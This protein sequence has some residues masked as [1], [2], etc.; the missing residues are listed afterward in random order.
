MGRLL[1]KVCALMC[2][3]LAL[4]CFIVVEFKLPIDVISIL[5]TNCNLRFIEVKYILQ[6]VSIVSLLLF[7]LFSIAIFPEPLEE[8]KNP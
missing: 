7:G 2:L 6:G 4:T 8:S 1:L 5:S 3:L